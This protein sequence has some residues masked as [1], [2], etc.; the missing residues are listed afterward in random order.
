M[1]RRLARLQR[2]P[3]GLARRVAAGVEHARRKAARRDVPV[4]QLLMGDECGIAADKFARLTGQPLRCSTPISD[5]PHAQLLRLHQQRGDAIFAD[6]SFEQSAYYRNAALCIDILGWYF[7]AR[8]VEQIADVA[9]RYIDPLHHRADVGAPVEGRS[10]PDDPI[11]VR[12]IAHS[13]CWQ[14]IDG[15][16]RAALAA[17]RG[18]THLEVVPQGRPV[19]TPLQTTLLDVLWLQGRREL[20]QPVDAPE[21]HRFTL[22]RRC[23]DRLAKMSA[24]LDQHHLRGSYLDLGCSYGWFVAQMQQRGFDACGVERDPVAASVGAMC[25][26]LDPQRIARA[27]VVRFLR[28]NTRTFDIVSCFSVLH[29]FALGLNPLS[30][31]TLI[32]LVDA[33]TGRVLFFDTGQGTEQWFAAKLPQWTPAY[34][35]DWLKQHTTFDE[36]H[37]LGPDDDA[38]P[39]F[40]RQYGRTLFACV[41]HPRGGGA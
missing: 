34:I 16:H 7:D 19:L 24:F 28:E 29:H 38:R 9:R 36:I 37:D 21:L 4:S 12:P 30:A 35:R 39:P 8:Q 32:Q 22:V 10:A 14:I 31:E 41:R 40:E 15:H 13:D 6:G 33:A 20:Y 2:L 5:S 25:Y 11:R 18:Q 23:T 27:D 17:V 1:P 3:A 26:G